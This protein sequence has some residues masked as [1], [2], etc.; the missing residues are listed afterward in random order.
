MNREVR[1]RMAGSNLQLWMH[2]IRLVTYS[3]PAKKRK[4][5]T[6]EQSGKF[7]F[8]RHNGKTYIG[9]NVRSECKCWVRFNYW[10]AWLKP[11][12]GLTR[13]SG[14]FYI[15]YFLSSQVPNL[16]NFLERVRKNI[17]EVLQK[18][19]NCCYVVEP[20]RKYTKN[21][22][23]TFQNFMLKKANSALNLKLYNCIANNFADFYF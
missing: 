15:V 16:Q 14:M 20:L 7:T 5:I 23:I 17:K 8:A 12:Q 13:K 4:N 1:M 9:E 10:S 22:I 3:A 2:V 21:R 11:K 19:Y 6:H 18:W